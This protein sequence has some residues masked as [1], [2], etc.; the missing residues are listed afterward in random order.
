MCYDT[1]M[2]TLNDDPIRRDPDI[3]GGRPCFAGTRVPVRNLFDLLMHG[4][5][6]EEFLR[7]FPTVRREQAVAVLALAARG[8]DLRPI[9]EP[10]GEA[11]NV[12]TA[13]R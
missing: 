9:N 12:V 1:V 3:L 7:A 4:R 11:L 6:L 10:E 8:L 2:V 13:T 5:S